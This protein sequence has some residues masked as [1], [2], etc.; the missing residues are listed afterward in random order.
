MNEMTL[1]SALAEQ[2]A[3]SRATAATMGAVTAAAAV[4]K[5]AS[6]ARAAAVQDTLKMPVLLG[7][8]A[9]R[10]ATNGIDTARLFAFG[11][12]PETWRELAQMQQAIVE[13]LTLQQQS[14]MQGWA[15]W[16]RERAEI[17]GANTVTKLVEQEFNLIAQIGQLF[18]DQTTN[19]IA[20]QENIEVSYAYWL[21]QKL[22]ALSSTAGVQTPVASVARA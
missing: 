17:R 8:W 5:T 3:A 11:I 15:A 13:R 12:N 9:A 19:L 14:W 2:T 10:S 7:G 4:Q 6:S 16:N 21:N 22:G 18:I 1:T 20:L